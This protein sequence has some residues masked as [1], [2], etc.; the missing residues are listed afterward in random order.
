MTCRL[1]RWLLSLAVVVGLTPAAPPVEE[2]KTVRPVDT[3]GAAKPLAE[4]GP[5][6]DPVPRPDP[7]TIDAALRR[8]IAFLV[9]SQNK[10]GSWGSPEIR[11]G[12]EIYAPV[13]GAHQAFQ[14]AVSA[15]A[16]SALTEAEEV[17]ALAADGAE[18]RRAIDRGAAWLETHLPKVRRA[19][20]DA[21]YN[22]WSH[23]YGIQALVRIYVRAGDP[24]HRRRLATLIQE[25]IDYLRRYESVDKGWGYYDFRAQTQRPASD[26]TS[27]LTAAIL[28]ALWEAHGIGIDVPEQLVQ[29]A[30]A[31]VQRQRLPDFSY[32]YGE[33]LKY[34]PQHGINRPG[35]SLG[36]TQACNLALRLWGDEAVTDAIVKNWLNRL[37]ARNGWLDMARKT[38]IPHESHFAVAGYFFYFGH[39]YAGLLIHELPAA[40]RPLY[41]DHLATLL[42]RL[43]SKDG[44]W[45]DY[46]LY[47]YHHAYGTAFGI[48]TLLRCRR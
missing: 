2:A 26:S 18:L 13:P 33:Y 38:T 15:L 45:W 41:Q 46:P 6:L 24:G 39:Y 19:N 42:L 3:G 8:A 5:R 44:S 16:I 29:G 4:M 43:Q 48:M 35:G 17:P 10:N 34:V 22:C 32:L 47:N 25:Q 37:F 20:G 12:V 23:A 14:A 36:R 27:F 11:G 9:Q 31:S 28:V 7:T 21:L 40:E 1:R 30:V